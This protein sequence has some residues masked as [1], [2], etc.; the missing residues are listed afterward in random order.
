MSHTEFLSGFLSHL[1]YATKSLSNY[2]WILQNAIKVTMIEHPYSQF[3][4]VISAVRSVLYYNS[5]LVFFKCMQHISFYCNIPSLL[6]PL[7]DHF[8]M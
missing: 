4:K 2:I 8:K 7:Y 3:S 6:I 5:E 1:K